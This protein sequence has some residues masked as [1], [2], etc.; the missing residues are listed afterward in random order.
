RTRNS[1][2]RTLP[3]KR[4]PAARSPAVRS[5]GL[6]GNE[7][8]R[9]AVVTV[10]QSGRWRPVV[11]DVPLMA[12]A[13]HAVIF[14]PRLDEPEVIL[15][16]QA[17]GNQGKETWPPGAAVEFHLRAEKRQSAAGADEHAG[18]LLCIKWARERTLRALLAQNVELRRAEQ[19]LP[20]GFR[21]GNRCRRRRHLSARREQARPALL[22]L[23]DRFGGRGRG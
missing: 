23:G 13:A 19:L 16:G 12:G 10:A 1:P 6:L 21:L 4:C 20:F 9:H 18:A 11:E 22:D 8:K 3:A 14:G 15:R 17:A 5:G 2:L 7:P